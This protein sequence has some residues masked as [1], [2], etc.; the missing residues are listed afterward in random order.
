[1][2]WGGRATLDEAGAL[3]EPSKRSVPPHAASFRLALR[4]RSVCFVYLGLFA[5][6]AATS[7][8]RRLLV[9]C[10]AAGLCL[11]SAILSASTFRNAPAVHDITGPLVLGAREKLTWQSEVGPA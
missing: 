11:V 9:G 7:L 1:G 2:L 10:A 6:A 3:W 4:S 5:M 8:R